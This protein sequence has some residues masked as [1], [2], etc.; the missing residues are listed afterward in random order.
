[1]PEEV[2]KQEVET[3]KEIKGKVK[4]FGNPNNPMP[5]VWVRIAK[6]IRYVCTGM[7]AL[8]ATAPSFTPEQSSSWAF[9]LA[10]TILASGGIELLVGVEPS[11]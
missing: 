3:T 9:W 1:M 10:V 5:V 4:W 11:K 6:A 7:I 2:T 8:T